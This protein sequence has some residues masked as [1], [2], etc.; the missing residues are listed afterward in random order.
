MVIAAAYLDDFNITRVTVTMLA[1]VL[2]GW[3]GDIFILPR[4]LG[5]IDRLTK[6]QEKVGQGKLE[7]EKQ[8]REYEIL[9]MQYEERIREENQRK[10]EGRKRRFFEKGFFAERQSRKEWEKFIKAKYGNDCNMDDHPM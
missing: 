4:I 2:V 10:L 3:I 6:K 7:Q 9:K 5:L 1:L 8:E